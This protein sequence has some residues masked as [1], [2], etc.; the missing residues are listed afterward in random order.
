VSS[1]PFSTFYFIFLLGCNSTKACYVVEFFWAFG[2]KK[3]SESVPSNKLW[4]EIPHRILSQCY[5]E[6]IN[7]ERSAWIILL[8]LDPCPIL[9]IR[10]VELEPFNFSNKVLLSVIVVVHKFV[11]CTDNSF[12]S[13]IFF[14]HYY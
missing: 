12:P 13:S 14:S 6:S 3:L 2:G 5:I 4:K 1:F 7:L 8:S 9:Q 10:C 11:Y